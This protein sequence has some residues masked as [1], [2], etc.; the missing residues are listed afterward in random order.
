MYKCIIYSYNQLLTGFSNGRNSHL[1]QVFVVGRKRLPVQLVD[2]QG[3]AQN[4]ALGVLDRHAQDA[5]RDVAS[6]FINLRTTTSA[7][8]AFFMA[9]A[10]HN[11]KAVLRT[12]RRLRISTFFFIE[13]ESKKATL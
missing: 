10:L 11:E 8:E 9:A 12:T 6:V 4:G 1:K 2:E 5:S 3:H 13:T 7:I